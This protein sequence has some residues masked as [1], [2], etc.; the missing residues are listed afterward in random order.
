VYRGEVVGK[1]TM[2]I[3]LIGYVVAFSQTMWGWFLLV[4]VPVTILL[5]DGLWHLYL[6]VAEP[7]G[8]GE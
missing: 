6:S 5:M 2:S 4:M 1:V 8:N 3:P 7:E